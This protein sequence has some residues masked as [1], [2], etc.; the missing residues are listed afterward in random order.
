MKVCLNKQISSS[1]LP[2]HLPKFIYRDLVPD[3]VADIIIR[4]DRKSIY[5]VIYLPLDYH[6]QNPGYLPYII[7]EVATEQ[8]KY[9]G[10][11][12]MLVI[13]LMESNEEVSNI[14]QVQNQCLKKDVNM[15]L[16]FEMSEVA[17]LIV[18]II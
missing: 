6:K 4:K 7:D 5:S 17:H 12:R 3:Q 14:E 8:K 18:D 2:S 10:S 11:N 13:L 9:E 16:C 1:R 15:M